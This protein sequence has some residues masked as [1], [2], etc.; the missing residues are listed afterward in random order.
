[1]QIDKPLPNWL[2]DYIFGHLKAEE[3]PN[4][5]EFCKNLDSDD[6]KNRIYLGTYFPRS[7]AE[8]YCI[9]ANM[10][11][12]EPYRTC[13]LAKDK[14]SVLSIGCGTGGD[15][16]GLV[17][18][19]ARYLPHIKKLK[20]V[21]FDGNNIA[22]D[23][24]SDL[25]DLGV[26]TARFDIADKDK[27]YVPLPVT[28][29]E[30]LIHYTDHMGDGYDLITSF[31]FVNELMDAGIFKQ[32]GFKV[33]ADILAPKLN[34]TGLLT[35]LDV[36]DKHY[37]VFQPKNLNS[38]LCAFSKANGGFKTLL[39]IPC[40]F[41]DKKCVGGRCFTNKRFFGT[42]TADDKVAY[43]VIGRSDFV[44]ALYKNMKED[45]LYA[46][47]VDNESCPGFRGRRTIADAFDI[48]S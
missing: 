46:R 26:I 47:N 13:L 31:K 17:C 40:H 44:D 36:T 3:K 21:A 29:V 27:R 14:L 22:I 18:A 8:S 2:Y 30:D 24:L 38:G 32:D 45:V 6:E 35:I 7:F 16:L 12:Y 9:H 43:R 37:E 28:C 39:P 42:F 34:E 4:P 23:Y 20:I 10:F 1:M 19:I 11:G 15:I 5:R 48:N 41:Y 25:L 33:L